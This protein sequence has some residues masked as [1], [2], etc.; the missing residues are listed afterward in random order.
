M[1]HLDDGVDVVVGWVDSAWMDG[2]GNTRVLMRLNDK[3]IV[4]AEIQDKITYRIYTA[5]GMV[6][7]TSGTIHRTFQHVGITTGDVDAGDFTR[8]SV[9]SC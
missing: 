8:V 5:M 9:V 3:C 2:Q 6:R 7:D 1:K 4:A